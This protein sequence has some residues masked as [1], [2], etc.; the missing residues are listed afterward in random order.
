MPFATERCWAIWQMLISSRYVQY[1]K[2]S[3]RRS[4]SMWARTGSTNSSAAAA[5]ALATTT[6]MLSRPP[7]WFER[8]TIFCTASSPPWLVSRKASSRWPT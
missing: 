6:V 1:W 4:T 5:S 7:R 8:S 3:T 2:R